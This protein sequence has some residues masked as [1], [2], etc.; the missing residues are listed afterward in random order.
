MKDIENRSRRTTYRGRILVHAPIKLDDRGIPQCL[1]PHQQQQIPDILSW[2]NKGF[3]CR[4]IIG[5]VEIVNCVRGHWSPW[6]EDN[7][8]HWVLANPVRFD[9]PIVDVPGALSFWE[10]DLPEEY[11]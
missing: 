2:I 11:R 9:K 7:S 5:S 8:W 6:A 4:A 1:T 10:Y 3:L